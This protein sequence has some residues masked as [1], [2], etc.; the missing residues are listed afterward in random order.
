MFDRDALLVAM[1]NNARQF[2]T[3]PQYTAAGNEGIIS[4]TANNTNLVTSAGVYNGLPLNSTL[5][6]LSTI[7]QFNAATQNPNLTSNNAN[8][9]SPGFIQLHGDQ[10]GEY[11]T[12]EDQIP[13][14]D[15]YSNSC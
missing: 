12:Y 3:I 10:P 6:N 8:I 2:G 1:E 13:P 7:I 5:N 14:F 9:N 4:V 15:I 11:W